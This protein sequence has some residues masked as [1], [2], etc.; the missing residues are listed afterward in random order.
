[1][2][3]QIDDKE[4][5]MRHTNMNTPNNAYFNLEVSIILSIRFLN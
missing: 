1:M 3:V 2:E 4:K 5:T